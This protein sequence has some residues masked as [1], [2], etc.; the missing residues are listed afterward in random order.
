MSAKAYAWARSMGQSTLEIVVKTRGHITKPH[1]CSDSAFPRGI[2]R[3]C[4]KVSK[5]DHHTTFLTFTAKA[6][7]GVYS[8]FSISSVVLSGQ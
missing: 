2:D 1:A 4:L 5:I 7:I 6:G 8:S 3:D